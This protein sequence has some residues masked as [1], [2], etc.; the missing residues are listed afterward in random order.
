MVAHN[1]DIHYDLAHFTRAVKQGEP[2]MSAQIAQWFAGL[3]TEGGMVDTF[4]RLHPEAR[5]YSWWDMRTNARPQN[6]GWRL[7]YCMV[8]SDLMPRVSEACIL[9]SVQGSDHCPVRVV[10]DKFEPPPPPLKPLPQSSRAWP[11]QRGIAS[12]FAKAPAPRPP[13]TKRDAPWEATAAS[14]DVEKRARGAD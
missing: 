6:L 12:F 8:S 1:I 7:D 11:V 13:S 9:G 2:C 5:E 10:V 4:R 14:E 3:Q